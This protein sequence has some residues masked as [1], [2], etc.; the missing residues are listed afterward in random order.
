M[1]RFLYF[2]S[3][4]LLSCICVF[5]Q[6]QQPQI[7]CPQSLR[8]ARST[9]DQGRLHEVPQWLTGCLTKTED[10]GGFTDAERIE[11]YRMLTLTYI[12]LEE[13][14][15]AD[16]EMIHL[17]NTDH[18]Y[19][20]DPDIDPIEFK[21]LY[22]KFRTD[23]VYRMGLKLGANTTHIGLLA[24]RYMWGAGK[25]EYSSTPSFQG[26]V[27]FE[28]D[29]PWLEKKVTL[30]PELL[31]NSNSFTYINPGI[32]LI[33]PDNPGEPNPPTDAPNTGSQEQII[34]Q[35]RLQLNALVQYRIEKDYLLA[36]KFTPYVTLGPS[37]NYLMSSEF[38]G[39]TDADEP[40]TGTAIDNTDS[41]K[42]I[43]FSVIAAAGVKFRFGGFYLALEL[44]HQYGF[45]NIVNTDNLYT[46]KELMSYG[47][48][49]NDFRMS[50][51][52][53]NLTFILPRF[54]PKKLIK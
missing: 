42:R 43:T 17:L 52:Q 35:T 25:G 22:K 38:V 54:H 32:L 6:E 39:N 3:F 31:Y 28:K 53:F 46:N 18:F 37:V 40:V 24:N 21:N 1:R 12:Y 15:Q 5:A 26:G 7:N 48:V 10:V 50:Q 11:A 41:Y 45:G 33:Q 20:I 30:A 16:A 29:M 2:G 36:D 19:T 47:Y 4:F 14:T 8:T 27:V 49:D 23:P 9:Y 13:P 34:T 51:T 44:R